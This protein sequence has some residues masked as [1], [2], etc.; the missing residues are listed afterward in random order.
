M[1]AINVLLLV[2]ELNVD[3]A[4]LE[5]KWS[6]TL[7]ARRH[8]IYARATHKIDSVEDYKL[9]LAYPAYVQFRGFVNPQFARAEYAVLKHYVK[10]YAGG[11]AWLTNMYGAFEYEDGKLFGEAVQRKKTKWAKNALE[12][13]RVNRPRYL[14]WGIAEIIA[15]A[16]FGDL[17]AKIY[18]DL[19]RQTYPDYVKPAYGNKVEFDVDVY[20]N[21][22]AMEI[23]PKII[24]VIT[25]ALQYGFYAAKAIGEDKAEDF[26]N[27]F[28]PKLIHMIKP[29][30]QSGVTLDDDNTRFVWDTTLHRPGVAIK[31]LK[32]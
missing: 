21:P 32:E 28:K 18:F 14:G 11:E 6:D 29:Y 10:V 1:P 23:K 4:S 17:R 31:L 15:H 9:Y 2:P 30:L 27:K 13:V 16:L 5:N 3:I 7:Y 25:Q 24:D 19:F 26:M 8:L 12:V 20:L 22:A